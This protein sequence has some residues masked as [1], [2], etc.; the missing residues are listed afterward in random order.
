M[1]YRD[2]CLHVSP[3]PHLVLSSRLSRLKRTAIRRASGSPPPTPQSKYL[4]SE[5]VL[6]SAFS[7]G[8]IK[9][10]QQCS[11]FELY[12]PLENE[13]D[14]SCASLHSK[15]ER[16]TTSNHKSFLS[17][18]DVQSALMTSDLL[19]IQETV[20]SIEGSI[21]D[22]APLTEDFKLICKVTIQNAP[23]ILLTAANKLNESTDASDEIR[24][25]YC[26]L[27][28]GFLRVWIYALERRLVFA[29]IPQSYL[30]LCG[31]A[32]ARFQDMPLKGFIQAIG[33]E[34]QFLTS[35]ARVF[36]SNVLASPHWFLEMLTDCVTSIID[37][38]SSAADVDELASLECAVCPCIASVSRTWVSLRADEPDFRPELSRAVKGLL[39]SI[40]V[41]IAES[42]GPQSGGRQRKWHEEAGPRGERSVLSPRVRQMLNQGLLFPL[43]DV[44]DPWAL[45]QSRIG[46]KPAVACEV[47]RTLLVS[48]QEKRRLAGD[49]TVAALTHQRAPVAHGA[50]SGLAGSRLKAKIAAKRQQHNRRKPV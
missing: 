15:V 14:S 12:N 8:T 5:L 41:R 31:F 30:Y 45:Q 46:L 47:L 33:L 4:L 29:E 28:C 49:E 24:S 16:K 39:D 50:V 43:L 11:N 3:M 17:H 22:N 36:R 23:A 6:A 7:D 21:L 13:F 19:K 34:S 44:I 2:T 32:N 10:V 27:F 1:G 18:Q 9:L 35:Y 38:L 25:I 48:H 40:I 20:K 42:S 26:S 37:R